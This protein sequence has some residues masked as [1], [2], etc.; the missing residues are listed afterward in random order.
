MSYLLSLYKQHRV[1][2]VTQKVIFG[3]SEKV[4]SIPAAS[5]VSNKINTS[6]V[7][8]YKGY[9]GTVRHMDARCGR[10]TLCFS[11]CQ[12]NH[13]IQLALSLGYYHLCL[14][15]KTLTKRYGRSTT[16]FM[17]VNLTDHVWSMAEL[18]KFKNEKP[19]S[20]TGPPPKIPIRLE[21]IS[22]YFQ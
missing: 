16:P 11:K 18:L 4:E 1:V 22:A 5:S 20:L 9:N 2:K 12:E 17:A 6:Y 3:D 15:H 10:K 14:P 21:I 7:E 19:C 13:K 8:G